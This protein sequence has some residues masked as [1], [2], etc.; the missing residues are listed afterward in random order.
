MK[1]DLKRHIVAEWAT[2][3][4]EDAEIDLYGRDSTKFRDMAHESERTRDAKK[5]DSVA[6]VEKR[7]FDRVVMMTKE[8]RGIEM[9]GVPVTD[10]AQVYKLAP[11]LYD[12]ALDFLSSRANFLPIA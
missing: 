10:A 9:D 8:I 12:S 7:A 3:K 4:I 11:G 6:D 5:T 1:L 2:L